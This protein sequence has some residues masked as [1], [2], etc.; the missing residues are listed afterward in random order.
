[1]TYAAGT[2]PRFISILVVL[3]RLHDCWTEVFPF[4]TLCA[5]P[6]CDELAREQQTGV[7]R[8]GVHTPLMSG[9]YWNPITSAPW[10]QFYVLC[11]QLYWISGEYIYIYIYIL[12]T[13]AVYILHC[14]STAPQTYLKGD[15]RS[16]PWTATSSAACWGSP[17]LRIPAVPNKNRGVVA[18]RRGGITAAAQ[19]NRGPRAATW[20]PVSC[21]KCRV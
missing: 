8:S 20:M 6:S 15:A 9:H 7:A 17:S 16:T 1:M 11:L 14:N 12:N 2:S 21:I 18:R 13:H 4:Q 10:K 5:W 3:R 19:S